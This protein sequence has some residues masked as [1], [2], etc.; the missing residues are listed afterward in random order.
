[1]VRARC[2]ISTSLLDF[3]RLDIPNLFPE[4]TAT[5]GDSWKVIVTM[6]MLTKPSRF[7][8]NK[9]RKLYTLAHAPQAFWTTIPIAAFCIFD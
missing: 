3:V 5:T 8:F 2:A 6:T 1:M 9:V 7:P 4:L